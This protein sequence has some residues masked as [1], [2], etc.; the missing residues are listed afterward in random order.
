ME[1]P[2]LNLD[3]TGTKSSTQLADPLLSKCRIRSFDMTLHAS[4]PN[5]PA[6]STGTGKQS[7]D[8]SSHTDEDPS[9]PSPRGKE[10]Y[11]Y[12]L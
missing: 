8:H 3:S 11:R 5:S 7:P 4:P 2:L 6:T 10:T 1:L 9:C 12:A